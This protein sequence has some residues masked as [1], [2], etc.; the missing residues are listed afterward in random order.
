[1]QPEVSS[2]YCFGFGLQWAGRGGTKNT[3]GA[4][5]SRNPA[6]PREP[7]PD[8]E[9]WFR[10]AGHKAGMLWA[11]IPPE[12]QCSWLPL[13]S[14][15]PAQAR[16]THPWLC[17]TPVCGTHTW[18][19]GFICTDAPQFGTFTTQHNRRGDV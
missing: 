7:Q 8:L 5:R 2:S 10:G 4:E 6:E 11:V 18:D 9:A 13:S 16:V 1:M 19:I 14:A 3:E 12:P 15:G 17:D